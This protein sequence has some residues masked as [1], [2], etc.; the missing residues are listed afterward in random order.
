MTAGFNG[1]LEVPGFVGLPVAADFNGGPVIAGLNGGSER[2]CLNAG[3]VAAGFIGW[4]MATG[5]H[6]GASGSSCKHAV[7]TH[8]PPGSLHCPSSLSLCASSFKPPVTQCPKCFH[9]P[10]LFDL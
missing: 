4:A 6:G 3:P 10:L 8:W 1:R 5:L 2:P 9:C 7:S